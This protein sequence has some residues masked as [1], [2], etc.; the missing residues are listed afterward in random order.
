LVLKAKKRTQTKPI[1]LRVSFVGNFC[2]MCWVAE[3]RG[4][5]KLGLFVIYA[6][7]QGGAGGVGEGGHV[8]FYIVVDAWRGI[9]AIAHKLLNLLGRFLDLRGY[10]SPVGRGLGSF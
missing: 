6:I 10:R 5:R 2:G 1:Y 7:C 4:P 3:F 9:G 8:C